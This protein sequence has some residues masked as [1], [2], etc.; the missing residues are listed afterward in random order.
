LMATAAGSAGAC[1]GKAAWLTSRRFGD[2]VLRLTAGDDGALPV[3]ARP[4]GRGT[5]GGAPNLASVI[6]PARTGIS[7]PPLR[8][9]A[10][11]LGPGDPARL[12]GDGD[13][14]AGDGGRSVAL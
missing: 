7:K 3:A 10:G 11:V 12:P 9:D 4:K 1:L 5:G 2:G 8:T 6:S 13:R 14:F